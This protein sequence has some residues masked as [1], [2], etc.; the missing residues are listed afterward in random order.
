M[1]TEKKDERSWLPICQL[2]AEAAALA[3]ALAGRVGGA[4]GRRAHRK[5]R[6]NGRLAALRSRSEKAV[7]QNSE[8]GQGSRTRTRASPRPPAAYSNIFG[9]HRH[10]LHGG[11]TTKVAPDALHRWCLGDDVPNPSVYSFVSSLSLFCRRVQCLH[12]CDCVDQ[13]GQSQHR[14]LA[15]RTS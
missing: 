8:G 11:P 9:H 12:R 4:G 7:I 13:V 2:P 3:L 15:L 1:T 6:G 5:T 14:F 10:N